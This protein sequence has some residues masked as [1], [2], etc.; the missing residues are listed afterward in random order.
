MAEKIGMEWNGLED[1]KKWKNGMVRMRGPNMGL[2]WF[3]NVLHVFGKTIFVIFYHSKRFE[4][5]LENGLKNSLE[6]GLTLQI[7]RWYK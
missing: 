7:S 4:N 1:W 5:G 3:E 2:E 6:N